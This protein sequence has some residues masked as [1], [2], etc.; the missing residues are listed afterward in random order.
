MIADGGCKML[1]K[2]VSQS[3]VSSGEFKFI[4]GTEIFGQAEPAD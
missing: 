3:K 1:R 2:L 4:K